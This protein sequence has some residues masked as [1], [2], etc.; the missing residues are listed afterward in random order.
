MAVAGQTRRSTSL[1]ARLAATALIFLAAGLLL[2]PLLERSDTA[3]AVSDAPAIPAAGR[4]PSVDLRLP[5]PGEA[6]PSLV[7]LNIRDARVEVV[8]AGLERPW[9]FEFID[10]DEVLITEIGGRLLRYRFGDPAPVTVDGLPA[11]ATSNELLGLLDVALHPHFASNRRIYISYS[12][13]DPQAQQYT[14][15]AV[16][17]AVLDG[18][19][20]SGLQVILEAGPYSWSYSNSGGALAF[21]ADGHLYVSIGDRS[22]QDLA[23]R[24]DRLQGKILRLH[25]DG[26][27]PA[28]NPFVG[29]PV[30]DDR[31]YALGVRNPQGL[32]FDPATGRLFEAEH[33]PMG[34]DEVNLIEAGGNY[35]WPVVSYGMSYRLER[36]G[37]GTHAPGLRQPLFYYLPSEAVSP[38]LVYRGAMFPEWDGDLLVGTLKGQHVSR[39]DLDGDVVRSEYPIL[40]EL[41]AR[42]RDLKTG[43]DG[44]LFVLTE[45]GVLYRVY[46]DG[47]TDTDVPALASP[48][49]VYDMVCA[50]CHA[51]GAYGAPDPEQP[52]Q[53]VRILAQ[54]IAQT[55]RHARE[56]L[57]A[58][59]ERGLCH[60]CTDEQLSAVVEL[61]LDRVR[62]AEPAEGRSP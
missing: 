57:G 16:A 6:I 40:G 9:A 60:L 3:P 37:A 45:P 53:W 24:G 41:Q 48:A 29:T 2:R 38:L 52:A 36:I 19:A 51:G 25:D 21:D 18:Q 42:I 50:G 54:P 61:M 11:I 5:A 56:G 10:D 13:A 43:A 62:A 39:L 26:R 49:M 14:L 34:G 33:G 55:Q 22:E 23:Q 44:A 8:L 7:A 28:D 31:I 59:P 47:S 1:R 30:I 32:D 46:R 12:Q 4:Q 20:L 58:M 17:S 35:G 27:V 15:T